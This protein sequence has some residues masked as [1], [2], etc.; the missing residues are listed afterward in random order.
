MGTPNPA[1]FL[2]FLA[3]VGGIRPL[4]APGSQEPKPAVRFQ[5]EFC[6]GTG[7]TPTAAA[8][9]KEEASRIYRWAGSELVWTDD[10]VDPPRDEAHAARLYVVVDLPKPIR[11]R[12]LQDHHK[13]GLMGYIPTTPGTEPGPVIFVARKR[14]VAKIGEVGDHDEALA[15]ALGRVIAHELAHRFLRTGHTEHGILKD[16]FDRQDLLGDDDE[17]RFTPNQAEALAGAGDPDFE[18][19]C[20]EVHEDPSI[21]IRGRHV[22]TRLATRASNA[23]RSSGPFEAA[24]WTRRKSS[25]W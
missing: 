8:S 11:Y 25:F 18:L 24:S 4:A 19:K 1:Y 3:F 15:R 21:V 23:R 10:C 22:A 2:I 20:G 5:V 17:L 12:F 13:G 14:V 7:L 9:A 6:D 16:H